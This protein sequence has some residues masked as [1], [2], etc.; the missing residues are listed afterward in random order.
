MNVNKLI[1]NKLS[2]LSNELI[3]E[4]D[5]TVRITN[6]SNE[7][8]ETLKTVENCTSCKDNIEE[9]YFNESI[10]KIENWLADLKKDE[11]KKDEQKKEDITYK[12]NY[13]LIHV[14]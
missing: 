9:D 5:L 3:D 7:L 13:E 8:L 2:K 12:L 10:N 11:Q 14:D 1:I 6:L 4:N